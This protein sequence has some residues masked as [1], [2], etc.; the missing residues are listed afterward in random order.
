MK[1]TINAADD[2]EQFATPTGVNTTT[3]TTTPNLMPNVPETDRGNKNIW[4]LLWKY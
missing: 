1:I 2:C 4:I 3:T